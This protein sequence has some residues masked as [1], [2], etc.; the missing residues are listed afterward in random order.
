MPRPRN[1]PNIFELENHSNCVFDTKAF[2]EGTN[3]DISRLPTEML[4]F[5]LRQLKLSPQTNL[6][7]GT[8]L[9]QGRPPITTPHYVVP[10]SRGIVP[11]LSHDI[12]QRHTSI[13]VAHVAL[14]DCKTIVLLEQLR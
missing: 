3:G 8:L 12:L 5:T 9:R 6:R 11:H 2:M 10:T 14:E 13:S 1:L 7:L 4:S